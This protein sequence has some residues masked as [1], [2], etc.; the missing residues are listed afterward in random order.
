MPD[1]YGHHTQLDA[2]T[3]KCTIPHWVDVLIVRSISLIHGVSFGG[4]LLL[5][6]TGFTLSVGL[7]PSWTAALVYSVGLAVQGSSACALWGNY[8]RRPDLLLF[9]MY[10][11]V[12]VAAWV[13]AGAT[14]MYIL[15]AQVDSPVAK[16]VLCNWQD[17]LSELPEN[18]CSAAEMA[19][20]AAK[21]DCSDPNVDLGTVIRTTCQQRWVDD[22]HESLKGVNSIAGWVMGFLVVCAIVYKKVAKQYSTTGSDPDPFTK[23]FV[24]ALLGVAAVLALVLIVVSIVWWNYT[25]TSVMVRDRLSSIAHRYNASICM[26]GHPP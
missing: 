24:V 23:L 11:L 19:E 1:V 18:L 16:Y 25:Y 17:E 12:G 8:R 5:T 6:G 9:A 15:L 3:E 14:V 2:V 4:G 22:V 7:T 21:V 26:R 13:T 20:A 10:G